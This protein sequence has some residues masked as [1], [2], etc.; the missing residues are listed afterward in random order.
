MGTKGLIAIV[1]TA[2]VGFFAIIALSSALAYV[3]IFMAKFW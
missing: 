3:A 1:V 2:I